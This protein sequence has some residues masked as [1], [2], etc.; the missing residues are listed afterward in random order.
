ML[1]FGQ[2]YQDANPKTKNLFIDLKQSPRIC[3]VFVVNEETNYAKFFCI[4][5]SQLRTEQAP[6]EVPKLSN[7]LKS[8]IFQIVF[9]DF[10]KYFTR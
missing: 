2:W 10:Y 8:K 5:R 9:D 3:V 7:E 1:K 6:A 4:T